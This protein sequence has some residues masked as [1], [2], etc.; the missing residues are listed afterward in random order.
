MCERARQPRPAST[1]FPK[2][3]TTGKVGKNCAVSFDIPSHPVTLGP[4]AGKLYRTISSLGGLFRPGA[5]NTGPGGNRHPAPLFSTGLDQIST[6]CSRRRDMLVK[7]A[8]AAIA[9]LALMVVT[10]TAD[11]GLFL[12]HGGCG[13]GGCGGCGA[14]PS[15]GG[16]GG[17]HRLHHRSRCCAPATCCAA[18]PTCCA[19]A[20]C[21]SGCGVGY[22]AA[23][24]GAPMG[25][26]TPAPPPTDAPPPP[27]NEAPPAPRK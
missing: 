19:P 8:S 1:C 6:R 20:A 24:M 4:S 17:C 5:L 16:C 7:W 3:N 11:A 25:A 10:S 2:T 15:C 23:P 13:Y 14:A 18:A 21:G 12:H 22:G 27:A 9:A 26:G